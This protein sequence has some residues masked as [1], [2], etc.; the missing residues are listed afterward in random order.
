MIAFL[1][2]GEFIS[3]RSSRRDFLK[4]SGCVLDAVCLPGYLVNS[5]QSNLPNQPD[6]DRQERLSSFAFTK[7]DLPNYEV[8]NIRPQ[9]VGTT[10]E[11]EAIE[12]IKVID[13][14]GI[15]IQTV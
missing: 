5:S 10:K 8:G 15:D 12:G 3:L 2:M 9:D 1:A 4:F 6:S 7:S 11:G 14:I 13:N